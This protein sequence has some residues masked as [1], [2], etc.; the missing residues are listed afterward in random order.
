MDQRTWRTWG[1]P[2][3]GPGGVLQLLQQLV[4]S[5][6]GIL[7]I[8]GSRHGIQEGFYQQQVKLGVIPL[9][10]YRNSRSKN[11]SSR[12]SSAL[13]EVLPMIG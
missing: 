12:P 10:S 11:N 13:G 6:P 4:V 1:G 2:G 5:Q 9:S 3:G 8:G 7:T